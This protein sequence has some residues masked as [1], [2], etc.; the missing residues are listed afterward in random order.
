MI[1]I[2]FIINI[3]YNLLSIIINEI[4]IY[5]VKWLKLRPA[6]DLYLQNIVSAEQWYNQGGELQKIE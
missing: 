2:I 4:S 3:V 6:K 5:K 1:I